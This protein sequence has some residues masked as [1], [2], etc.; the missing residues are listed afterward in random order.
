MPPK[1]NK[2]NRKN[3]TAAT[4]QNIRQR[5]SLHTKSYIYSLLLLILAIAAASIKAHRSEKEAH[6][7][8]PIADHVSGL[9][10]V[11]TNPK[12]DEKIIDYAGMRISFNPGMHIPNWVA[13][14]L[15]AEEAMGSGERKNQ[16]L[17]DNRVPGC[18]LPSDYSHTGY[19]RGHMAPAGDMKWSP[20]AMKES[21]FMTNICP[22]DKKLNSGS[23][24]RLEEKCREW[25]LADSAIIII[26]GPVLTDK[27]TESIGKIHVR[28][29]KRFFKVLLSPYSNPP[30]AIGFIMPNGDVPGGMQAAA[31]SVDDVEKITGHNFFSALPDQIENIVESQCKFH[32]WSSIK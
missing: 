6:S 24:K 5:S 20:L 8:S 17:P 15:T 12:L 26:A 3:T 28:V 11:E 7:I 23:W 27:L 19:D 21:F 30:R 22:Q 13:W 10:N 4:K 2:S 14:E 31:M 9:E 16:F 32:L 1:Q 29:P 18:P 25:A